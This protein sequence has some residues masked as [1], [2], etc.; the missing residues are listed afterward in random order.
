MKGARNGTFLALLIVTLGPGPFCRCA[1]ADEPGTA[2]EAGLTQRPP[3]ELP[4]EKG[5][6]SVGGFA[7]AFNSTLSFGVNSVGVDIN[8]EKLLNLDTELTVFRLNALYRPGESRRNQLDFTYA[9]Y[10]R[11][12]HAVLNQQIEIGDVTFPVGATVDTVFNFD[13]IRGTY[14]YALLQDDRMRI[15]LGLGL[16][17]VPLKC[18]FSG[19]TS[20]GQ[21]TAEGA[22]VTLPL[23]SLA[24]R[25][26]FLL[27]RKLYL[28]TGV[29][30][31][32]LEI[33]GF[34]GSLFD[35]N[36]ALEYRPWKHLGFGAGY[37]GFAV[38]VEGQ[39]T[40]SDYPGANFIGHVGVHFSGLMLY[41]KVTF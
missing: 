15:A 29:D 28:T 27:V 33:S 2:P 11:S 30:A 3:A 22:D 36:A 39:N 20:G 5:S 32:Y 26:D 17:A 9:A 37:N 31:M 21:V 8:A 13:I 16:Y 6:V 14:S 12:G 18:S 35:V 4:W 1:V 19:Q 40:H 41:T 10:H 24:L 7:A 25:A 34:K 23:P 38:D